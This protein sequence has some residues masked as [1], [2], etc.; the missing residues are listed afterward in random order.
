MWYMILIQNTSPKPELSTDEL[1]YN[2][3]KEMKDLILFSDS[4][5]N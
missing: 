2:G 1:N 4:P 3:K 5:E